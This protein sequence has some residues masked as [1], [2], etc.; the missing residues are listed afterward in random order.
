V[1]KRQ[2]GWQGLGP[3]AAIAAA[4]RSGELDPVDLTERALRAAGAAGHLNAVVHLD[5]GGALA[6]AG[7]HDRTGA[8]AGVP[9]LVKEIIEVAALPFRCGSHA[10][11]DRIGERDAEIVRRLRA[12]GAVIVGLSH[13]HEF[14]YGCT[15]TSNRVGPSRNPHDPGRLTGGSSGGAGAAVAAGVVPLAL[16]TDTAGSVR[17]PA[18]LCGVVGAKPARGTLPLDGVFPLAQSLDHVG[19]LATTVADAEYAVQ[20]LA[21]PLPFTNRT[22]SLTESMTAA[23]AATADANPAEAGTAPRFGLPSNPEYLDHSAEV[24]RA[25][26]A[27]LDLLRGAGATTTPIALPDWS[28][29]TR[30]STDLQGPEAVANHEGR[31]TEAYQPDVR[32]RLREAAAVPA[33]RY[34]RARAEAVRITSATEDLLGT[35]DAVLLP[36]VPIVAPPLTATEVEGP[37]GPTPVRERLLRNTRLT[38]LTGHPSFSL[39]LPTAGL[40][41]G[42]QIIAVDN[43]TGW[44][45]ARWIERRLAAPPVPG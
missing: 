30:T 32:Q 8:L 10:L 29:L 39:P 23:P 4:V 13:S 41:V 42:L 36:T 43:Q 20:V 5:P 31:S 3:V 9:V 12:A 11:A 14:A 22:A 21:D 7:R 45:V 18:A 15:G 40:P 2:G 27:A 33:W 19:M 38:N 17:I 1:G 37:A 25:W 24:G 34:V 26:R 6:A 35:V 16:G 28:H 44:R